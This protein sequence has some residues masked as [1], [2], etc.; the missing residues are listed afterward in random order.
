MKKILFIIGSLQTGGA[1]TVLV[2]ILNNLDLKKFEVDL[3]L[4]ERRGELLKRLNKKINVKFLTKGNDGCNNNLLCFFYRIYRSLIYRFLSKNKL[5]VRLLYKMKL[6]KMYDVEIAFLFGVPS[7][8]IQKSPNCNSKKVMWVHTDISKLSDFEIK[9][10]LNAYN[11]FDLIVTNCN[12]AKESFNSVVKDK[13]NKVIVINNYVD[14]KKIKMMANEKNKT[15]TTNNIHL[16]A[17]GRLTP[18]KGF[19]R[20][21][22]SVSRINEKYNDYDLSI[23][24]TGKEK[25]NLIS[26]IEQYSCYNV[27][28]LGLK[29]NPYPYFKDC[30]IFILSSIYESYPTVVVEAMILN[31][32]IVAT[33]VVG[34]SE[35]LKNYEKSIIVENSEQG[36]CDGIETALNLLNKKVASNNAFEKNNKNSMKKIENLLDGR[37]I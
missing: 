28:L 17:V 3:L 15:F 16:L 18:V 24:G 14:I 37:K 23:L 31:K 27:N 6:K 12:S 34:V 30:D 10:Y 29:K 1:E 21:I 20:L 26:L 32:F 36:I 35:I 13:S 19:D 9:S 33:D 7:D 25:N 8:L 22:R 5:Y 4:V 2:D 11:F